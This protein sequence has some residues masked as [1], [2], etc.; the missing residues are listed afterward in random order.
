MAVPPFRS[1]QQA[2][3]ELTRKNV[4]DIFRLGVSY[5]GGLEQIDF[6]D[7]VY[8]L[9]SLP[10]TDPRVKTA[11]SDIHQHTVNWPDDWPADWVFSDDR[12][13]LSRGPDS[14]LLDFLAETLHPLVR[15]YE[16]AKSLAELLNEQLR[17]DGWQL[18]PVSEISG[19]PVYGAVPF[20]ASGAIVFGAARNIQQKLS[21]TYLAQQITRLQTA[22]HTDP[23][24]AIGTAKEFLESIAKTALQCKGQAWGSGDSF[25]SLVKKALSVLAVVPGGITR[26]SDTERAI[27]V[28]GANLGSA[29][30]KLAELRNWHGTGHGKQE[31]QPGDDFLS[32]HHARFVVGVS[33]L[34]AQFIYDCLQAESIKFVDVVDAD[35]TFVAQPEPNQEEYDPFADE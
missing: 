2:L 17:M 20:A 31:P 4:L 5:H 18:V 19:R 35:A 15:P 29:V 7:R 33:I 27:R 28:L 23:E 6:L 34:I 32:E 1:S 9:D 14:V 11:R 12:F 26:K 3:S 8:D 21:S 10:S 30:D 13:E 16:E 25:P 22:V 24:L